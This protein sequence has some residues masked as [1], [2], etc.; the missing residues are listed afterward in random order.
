MEMNEILEKLPQ[1]LMDFV[2][3]Q[4]YNEYT[5]QDHAVWRYVMRQNVN[6]LSKV[7]HESYVDGLRQTGISIDEIPH[8]YGMNRILKKIGWAAVAVDGFI[9][10]AAFMEFQAYN[11]LVIAADIR[12]IDQIEYT[13]APDIIHEAAG[14]API[15]ANY[16]YSVYLKRFGELGAKAFSSKRDYELYEA[17]RHLSILKADPYTPKEEIELAEKLLNQ[18]ENDMG[19]PSEMAKIRNLHWWTVEY[20]LIGDLKN[21]KIYG[22]GLLSSIGESMSCLKD[23]VLKLPYSIEAV[24]Y[25]FDITTKQPQLFVTP[26]FEHLNKVLDEFADCMALRKGGIDAINRAIESGNTATIV[27]SSGIQI[28]GTFSDAI[29][30]DNQPVFIKT[31]S[32]T[33]LNFKDKIID[34]HTKEYH[35]EGFS[36]PVGRIKNISGRLEVMS[37]GDLEYNNIIEGKQ[38]NLEYESGIN[39]TGILR[40]ITRIEGK[41][42]ILTFSDCSVTYKNQYLFRPEWGL[43]DLAVGDSIISGYN[44]P[45]DPLA[46]GLKYTAPKEK[47][48]K[49][50]HTEDAKKLHSYYAKVREIRNSNKTNGELNNVWKMVSKEYKDEWLLILELAE[51]ANRNKDLSLFS[52][53][54]AHLEL[55]K[56]RRPDYAHL[57]NNGLSILNNFEHN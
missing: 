34:G 50:I 17:I 36:S 18:I 43:Y 33:T 38:V 2:I 31:N 25:D 39:L 1:H 45:A 11:V 26:D 37:L 22:A 7:A 51:L 53:I 56:I 6:Y 27:L 44:G 8:M 29:V 14:H 15:I 48:H 52:D 46:F 54:N 20:G 9:P 23:D 4:P 32:P 30:I 24:D 19:K 5:A 12:P 42:L 28:S 21:P 13:P 10:P 55:L 49:I 3:D 47:T 16:E 40:K 57:I 35:S 41:N